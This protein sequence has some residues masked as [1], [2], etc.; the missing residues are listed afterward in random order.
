MILK[1]VEIRALRRE[2][3]RSSFNSGNIEV[4]RYFQR[5]AGQNQFNHH[6]DT[7]YIAL[8]DQ[9]IAGFVSISSGEMVAEAL[10]SVIKKHLPNYPIPVLRMV[11]VAVD[12]NFQRKGFGKRLLKT[13]LMIAKD[14]RE[15]YRCI[16]VVVEASVD[17]IEF[18][19]SFGFIIQ[20]SD[21]DET[22]SR[23]K[24]V[25]MLLPITSIDN[26]IL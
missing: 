23:Q 3:D 7:T 17:A 10:E 8:V 16:G 20:D 6:S 26:A 9:Q 24:S 1:T 21:F 22:K 18:Y 5:Y 13:A 4:D 12:K 15:R 2:D 14:K 19:K 25:S 11:R